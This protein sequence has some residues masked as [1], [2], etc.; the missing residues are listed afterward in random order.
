MSQ[1]SLGKVKGLY[2]VPDTYLKKILQELETE[3]STNRFVGKFIMYSLPLNRPQSID[4]STAYQFWKERHVD[5]PRQVIVSKFPQSLCLTE[6]VLHESW[7]QELTENVKKDICSQGWSHLPSSLPFGGVIE[8]DFQTLVKDLKLGSNST[9]VVVYPFV[10]ALGFLAAVRLNLEPDLQSWYVAR[11]EQSKGKLDVPNMNETKVDGS[12]SFPIVTLTPAQQ[13]ASM[14]SNLGLNFP[15]TLVVIVS[16]NILKEVNAF[17]S[18]TAQSVFVSKPTGMQDPRYLSLR[19][20]SRD[21]WVMVYLFY[22]GLS[23]VK[24][25][26]KFGEILQYL[27]DTKVEALVKSLYQLQYFEQSPTGMT[28]LDA[29]SVLSLRNDLSS[30]A[31]DKL[32]DLQKEFDKVSL[33]RRVLWID[34]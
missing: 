34:A 22:K 33:D 32:D 27:L 10:I 5:D 20:S 14:I 30:A 31:L 19:A 24:N 7:R 26:K 28:E 16:K 15:E 25:Q 3:F 13:L 11:Q 18:Q 2:F 29:K 17:I 1:K 4:S 9:V 12:Y 8:S 23:H 21:Q 6:I